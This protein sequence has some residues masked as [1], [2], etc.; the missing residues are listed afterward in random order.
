MLWLRQLGLL[1]GNTAYAAATTL[2]VFFLGLAAGAR[3]W[4]ARAPRVRDPLRAYAAVELAIA[5]T[6][7]LY[8]GLSGLYH[9]LYGPLVAALGWGAALRGAKVALTAAVL[10]PPAFFMGGTFPLVAETL[11][12]R[13]DRLGAGGSLLYALNI[14]GGALGALLAGFY[15]PETIGFTASYGVAVALTALVSVA[16]FSL[17][18]IARPDGSPAVRVAR[19]AAAPSATGPLPLAALGALLSGFLTL[20]FEVLWTRLLAQVLNNSVYAFSAVL[21]TFLTSLGVGALVAHG[22]AR[23]R[24]T[25]TLGLSGLAAGAGLSAVLFAFLFF[26]ASGGLTYLGGAPTWFSHLRSVFGAAALLMFVPGVLMG[27]VFPYLFRWVQGQDPSP[28]RILGRLA[29]A[30]SLGGVLGA[31]VTGFLLLDVVGLWWSVLVLASLYVGFGAAVLLRGRGI[32][33]RGGGTLLATALVPALASDVGRLPVAHLGPEERLLAV[34]EGSAGTVAVVRDER[35]LIMRLNNHYVLGDTRS[36]AV[37]QIQAHLPLLLHP[38]PRA[39]FLLGMGTGITAGAALAHPIEQLVVTELVPDVITAARAA[40]A[41]FTG[42]LF[43]DR[44]VRI[45]PEDGRGYLAGTREQFDVVAAD[46]FTPWH[47]GTGSLYTVEHFR[48]VRD[49]LR[50]GGLFAQWL[51]LYQ[52]SETEFYIIAR[53]LQAVFPQVTMWRGDF[54]PSGPIVALIARSE[55]GPMDDAVVARNVRRLGAEGA[56]ASPHGPHMAGLFYVGNLTAL[57]PVLRAYPLNTDGRPV[58]EFLAPRTEAGLAPR[59]TGLRLARFYDRVVAAVPPERDPFLAGMR[60]DELKYVRAGLA[61]YKHHL[62]REL[63]EPDSARVYLDAFLA[64]VPPRDSGQRA[65]PLAPP[66]R[67]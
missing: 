27:G 34:W 29:A 33:L 42:E 38:A 6:A 41:P 67:P 65:P 46:L 4:G 9:A 55:P 53:T 24:W 66:D 28:G 12:R 15:L 40:F 48:N 63:D 22:L 51:P 35:N 47:A 43:G 54:S 25:L 18:A 30:N 60:A 2:S 5:L 14:G 17:A 61:F 11:I 37:E 36:I 8:F 32:L 31:F 13:G 19:P 20:G 26:R 10:F 3:A 49:R 1:F 45:L 62:Y 57:D 16:A 44:R 56:G 58:I 7:L 52:L 21:V 23:S 50:P 59:L 39:T 64:A